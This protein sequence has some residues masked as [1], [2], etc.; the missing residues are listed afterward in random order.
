MAVKKLKRVGGFGVSTVGRILEKIFF[1]GNVGGFGMHKKFFFSWI[2]AVIFAL[3]FAAR[4]P[5]AEAKA[6]FYVK[7]IESGNGDAGSW[8]NASSDMQSVI[9]TAK[10]GDEVWVAQG[11]YTPKEEMG[12]R[13]ACGVKIYGGFSGTEKKL[14]ERDYEKNKTILDGRRKSLH[15]VFAKD[16]LEVSVLDGFTVTG[17]NAVG[18]EHD[19]F[20]GVGGG[21]LY[22]VDSPVKVLNCVI[23][24]NY[25]HESG[26]GA[27]VSNPSGAEDPLVFIENCT[28][29]SNAAGAS[30]GGFSGWGSFIVT[31]SLFKGNSAGKCGGGSYG[32]DGGTFEGHSASVKNCIF[33]SNTAPYGG[34]IGTYGAFLDISKCIFMF[35]AAMAGGGTYTSGNASTPS[36]NIRESTFLYNVAKEGSDIATSS[37]DPRIEGCKFKG[38]MADKVWS[39]PRGIFNCSFSLPTRNEEKRRESFFSLCKRGSPEDLRR[40]IR[41]DR[42]IVKYRTLDG[43][44]GLMLASRFNENPGVVALLI[45]SMEDFDVEQ[46]D[47]QGRRPLML[48]TLNQSATDILPLLLSAG[49][50]SSAKDHSGKTALDYAKLSKGESSTEVALLLESRSDVAF[51]FDICEKGDV[52]DLKSLDLLDSLVNFKTSEGFTGLFLA[53]SSDRSAECISLLLESGADANGR[54]RYGVTPLI[55]AARNTTDPTV[56]SLLLD[57]GADPSSGDQGGKTPLMYAAESNPNPAVISLLLDAGADLNRSDQWYGRTPLMCAA[58]SNPNPAVISLLLDAGADPNRGNQYGSSTPCKTRQN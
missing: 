14:S 35:N 31:N 26:G 42:D 15:V 12:F 47:L 53:L 41:A 8:E 38:N 52:E 23:E 56:I 36:P 34:A 16:L 6:I 45:E 29:V 13:M 17:G 50:D 58:K 49:A 57:A 40:A 46:Q 9:D 32:G 11:T 10:A 44:N 5:C 39:D 18:R 1:N 48:A 21:G 2:F 4:I 3:S 22:I 54:G 20:S 43:W 25:A 37:S 28:F 7:Q 30:G 24:K 33:D 27:F 51:F 19:G 55:Y